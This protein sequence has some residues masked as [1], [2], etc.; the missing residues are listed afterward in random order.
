[1]ARVIITAKKG[2][3]ISVEGDGYIGARC[4]KD[5]AE[6]LRRLGGVQSDEKKPE[7]FL[8]PDATNENELAR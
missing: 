3:K 1:M 6:I 4:E 8:S 7:Y 2:G 5:T